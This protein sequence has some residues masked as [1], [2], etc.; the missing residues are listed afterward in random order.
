MVN[1]QLGKIYKIVNDVN[2]IVYIGSTCN[3]LLSTRMSQHRASSKVATTTPLYSAMNELGVHSFRILLIKP[4]PC[5]N[6]SELEA[7]EYTVMKEIK[8]T[9]ITLFNSII[10][11]KPSQF[12]VA[13]RSGVL[14]KNFKRGSIMFCKR[15]N[16]WIF[17]WSVNGK[18]HR[19]YFPVKMYTDWGARKLA[20]CWQRNTYPEDI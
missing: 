17:K 16:A 15:N 8:Q 12:T 19:K 11:G 18:A 6:K 1:Y 4:F 13:K 10:D 3:P 14:N 9:G 2:D 5:N 20:E 7:E